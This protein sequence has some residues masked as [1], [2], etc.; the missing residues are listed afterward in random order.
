MA[1]YESTRFSRAL[2]VNAIYTIHYFEYFRGYRFKGEAHDFWEF[3]YADR[4]ALAV[5]AGSGET[6]VSVYNDSSLA[7]L[8]AQYTPG[9]AMTILSY[10]ESVCMILIDGGVAYVS[11]WNVVY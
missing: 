9:T 3:I 5:R 6:M 10:G 4:G 7:S 11:T 8:K 2:E 1:H